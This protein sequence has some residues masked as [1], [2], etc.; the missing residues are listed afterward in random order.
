MADRYEELTIGLLKTHGAVLV[1]QRVHAVYK[2][3][4]GK[5]WTCPQTASDRRAWQNAY[6]DLRTHL[7]LNSE[8]R[9]TPG[10]RREKVLKP[11]PAPPKPVALDAVPPPPSLRSKMKHI[12]ISVPKKVKA[13]SVPREPVDVSGLLEKY[14]KH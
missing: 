9:G 6:T 4:S 8:T 12:R 3:P 2:F 13:V 11:N 1:R 14:K 5:V 10:E 7:G